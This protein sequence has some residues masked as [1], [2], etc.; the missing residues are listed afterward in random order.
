MS[1]LPQKMLSFS[2]NNPPKFE[3][4]RNERSWVIVEFEQEGN[5]TRITLTHLGWKEGEEWGQAYKYFMSAWNIVLG[6]LEYCTEYGPLNW[7]KPF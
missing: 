3:N 1:Y 4:I 5:G 6:R 7:G 2:W